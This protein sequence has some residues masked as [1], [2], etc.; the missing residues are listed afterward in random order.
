MNIIDNL[1]PKMEERINKLK[2]DNAKIIDNIFSKCV[3]TEVIFNSYKENFESLSEELDRVLERDNGSSPYSRYKAFLMKE[4]AH[5]ED[6]QLELKQ[7]LIKELDM[8]RSLSRDTKEDKEFPILAMV[9]ESVVQAQK[10]LK[11]LK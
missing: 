11:E 10:F 3:L 1:L 8:E 2:A 6:F 7:Q 5:A 4:I 9:E